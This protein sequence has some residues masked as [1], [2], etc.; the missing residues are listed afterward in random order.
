[1]S[2]RVGVVGA[3][4]YVGAELVRWILGHPRLTLAAATSRDHAGT[5]LSEAVPV[6]AGFTK[7]V[8]SA[9]DL[10]ALS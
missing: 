10:A 3:T 9:P 6:L 8:L 1:M 7:V 5:P 4:G 2:L